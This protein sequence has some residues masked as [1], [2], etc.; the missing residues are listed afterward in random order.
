MAAPAPAPPRRPTSGAGHKLFTLV[1]Y[2]DAGAG[3]VLLGEKLRGFGQGYLNGFG[4]KVEAEDES[5]HAAALREMKEECGL[6]PLDLTLQGL[7]TFKFD[8]N[9]QPWDVHVYT[10]TKCEGE[11]VATD[12]MRPVWVNEDAIPFEKM[13]ADDP[14]WYPLLLQG[15]KF[16]GHFDFVNTHTLTTFTLDEV[17]EIAPTWNAV[18]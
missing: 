8:D 1:L 17:A 18:A 14:H 4:G 2:R 10:C 7:C 13:W 5:V 3:R 15:K 16:K 6:T 9:P 11:L 12:E